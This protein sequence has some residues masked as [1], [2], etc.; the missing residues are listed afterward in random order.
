M[1]SSRRI[2]LRFA[3]ANPRLSLGVSAHMKL[4]LLIAYTLLSACA[5]R[6]SITP[7]YKAVV[8]RGPDGQ[9]EIELPYIHEFQGGN[10]HLPWDL[11][12]HVER[13]SYWLYAKSG[14][15]QLS[16][17]EFNLCFMKCDASMA[18]ALCNLSGSVQLGE[19]RL[20]LAIKE[21][22]HKDGE[23]LPTTWVEFDLNGEWSLN[24][25]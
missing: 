8:G 3:A 17:A 15:G 14:Q 22:H 5:L 10:V 13:K 2:C 9:L 1:H 12:K 21:P 11:A 6:E 25:R 4:L 18:Y 19:S 23:P 16:P 7:T 24:E 20:V